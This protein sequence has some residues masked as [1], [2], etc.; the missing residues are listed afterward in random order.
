MIK[1]ISILIL[2]IFLMGCTNNL[3][4]NKTE[5]EA[6]NLV[7][8][9]SKTEGFKE[10]KKLIRR[11]NAFALPSNVSTTPDEPYRLNE[12]SNL[13]YEKELLYANMYIR[14][15]K[16]TKLFTKDDT[17]FL[18]FPYSDSYNILISFNK[19]TNEKILA[20]KDLLDAAKIAAKTIASDEKLISKAL[21]NKMTNVDS[22]YFISEKNNTILTHFLVDTPT[23]RLHFTICEDEKLSSKA[24]DIMS[25][26]LIAMY[27]EGD[28]PL[29]VSKD[30]K[31]YKD[32]INVY[33]SKKI[34]VFGVKMKIPEN[35]FLSQDKNGIQAFI[36]K[37]DGEVVSEI[38]VKVDDK[39]S[40][41]LESLVSLNSGAIIYPA[42]I[43]TSGQTEYGRIEG[44]PFLRTRARLYMPAYSLKGDKV[45][46]ETNDKFL[47][48]F[49]LGPMN[50]NDQTRIMSSTIISSI[51]NNK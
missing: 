31:D 9:L 14:V 35:F 39:K 42:N 41:S 26:M 32:H 50:D 10:D 7:Y 27:K 47:T 36:S 4:K 49:I 44:L 1:K 16:K 6:S 22:A 5:E 45:V 34:D 17:Y 2:A 24:K 3:K 33:A 46:L 51:N 29:E 25:D 28:D 18:D 20:E 30:F 48:L 12:L 40:N 43:V 11:S 37:V 8:A 19:V 21:S 15:P 13:D 38:I 23:A